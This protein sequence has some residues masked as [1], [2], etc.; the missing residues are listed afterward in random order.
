MKE[1]TAPIVQTQGQSSRGGV[2][3]S[4]RSS[5]GALLNECPD[6]RVEETWEAKKYCWID[7]VDDGTAW[8]TGYF[9]ARKS[10]EQKII[11]SEPI[12]GMRGERRGGGE[13][14]A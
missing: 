7:Q 9:Y 10:S 5:R 3:A 12:S 4:M 14:Y 11:G 13:C 2:N 8:E 6:C 1:Q